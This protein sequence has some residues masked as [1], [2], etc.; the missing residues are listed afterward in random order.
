MYVLR[1]VKFE[2]EFDE[3][4]IN[5]IADAR[6]AAVYQ[7]I[8]LTPLPYQDPSEDEEKAQPIIALIDKVYSS[9]GQEQ[10]NSLS[11]VMA[12]LYAYNYGSSFGQGR[13][14]SIDT[15]ASIECKKAIHTSQQINIVHTFPVYIENDKL[16]LLHDA[17]GDVVELT[18]VEDNIDRHIEAITKSALLTP[19]RFIFELGEL[20]TVCYLTLVHMAKAGIMEKQDDQYILYPHKWH[21][22]IPDIQF[23]A[24]TMLRKLAIAELISFEDAR[25]N[26]SRFIRFEQ[27]DT[28]AFKPMPYHQAQIDIDRLIKELT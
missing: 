10:L 23:N 27:V 2:T 14:Y 11:K 22:I 3:K 8:N 4:V 12:C 5:I 9:Y 26:G 13:V 20:P 21:E 7:L 6:F 18:P 24:K 25:S 16:A 1:D 15:L 28:G 17:M 19:T